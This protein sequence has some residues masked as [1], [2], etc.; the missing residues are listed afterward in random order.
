MIQFDAVSRTVPSGAGPLTI[1]HPTS[2]TIGAGRIVAVTGA[3]AA[4]SRRC[5]A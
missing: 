1:L 5:W 4:E 3:L 2:F